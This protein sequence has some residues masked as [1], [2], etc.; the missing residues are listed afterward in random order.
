MNA[1]I[2]YLKDKENGTVEVVLELIG[3]PTRS[4]TIAKVVAE[5]MSELNYM[6]FNASNEFTALPP[7]RLQ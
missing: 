3:D 1:T 4:F 2:I 5:N 7:E 6:V